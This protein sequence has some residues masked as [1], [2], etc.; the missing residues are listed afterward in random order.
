M[1]SS[2]CAS[3]ALRL[4]EGMEEVEI[5]AWERFRD[6][7][8]TSSVARKPEGVR[9]V[10]WEDAAA[11]AARERSRRAL[12]LSLLSSWW[13]VRLG[14]VEGGCKLTILRVTS[15]VGGDTTWR[16]AATRG[17]V[18][19]FSMVGNVVQSR[20]SLILTRRG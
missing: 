2:F 19:G 12:A 16:D 17:G 14:G 3:T 15:G 5:E 6:E 7:T 18:E 8:E 9:A 10:G 11:S 20:D 13:G 1:P 4:V